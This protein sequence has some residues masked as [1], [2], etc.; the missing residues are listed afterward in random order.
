[1]TQRFSPSR[2]KV[3]PQ[4][5][6]RAWAIWGKAAKAAIAKKIAE[7]VVLKVLKVVMGCFI[8]IT[9]R[10]GY[11]DCFCLG[12]WIAIAV[13]LIAEGIK[14]TVAKQQ[15]E[16]AI[17]LVQGSLILA[18]G[19]NDIKIFKRIIGDLPKELVLS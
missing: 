19:L 8:K 6:G 1:M 12:G 17:I 10:I 15:A 11:R 4:F 14:V 5:L 18:Q 2:V 7:T 13:V 9:R 3:L 16:K